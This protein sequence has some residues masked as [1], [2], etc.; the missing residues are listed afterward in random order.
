M[1]L[2][3]FV[4]VH[5]AMVIVHLALWSKYTIVDLDQLCTKVHKSA[6]L[7]V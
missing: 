2:K 7:C 4:I 3:K 6:K 1:S 5:L